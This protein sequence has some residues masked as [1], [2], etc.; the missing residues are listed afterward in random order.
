MKDIKTLII[1][2]ETSELS[3]KHLKVLVSNNFIVKK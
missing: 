2:N 3:L 1:D